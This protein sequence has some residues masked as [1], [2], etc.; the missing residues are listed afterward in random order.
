MFSA[1]LYS[2][3]T[4]ERNTGFRRNQIKGPGYHWYKIARSKTGAD[5]YLYLFDWLL[6]V[7][8]SE[9]VCRF[10]SDTVFDIYASLKFTGPAFPCGKSGELNAVWCDRIVLVPIQFTGQIGM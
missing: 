1:G 5:E 4:G 2:Y 7:N 8:L 3:T 10:S 9:A 6:Q